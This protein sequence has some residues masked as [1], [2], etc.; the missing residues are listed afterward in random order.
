MNNKS[1]RIFLINSLVMP[2]GACSIQALKP[3]PTIPSLRPTTLISYIPKVGSTWQYVKLNQYNSETVEIIDE[4]I[5][6]IENNRYEISRES[7]KS[8]YLNNEVHQ[9]WGMIKADSDWDYYQTYQQ[10]IP[11][12]VDLNQTNISR[13]IQTVYKLGDSSY[14]LALSVGI[15]QFGWELVTTRAGVFNTIRIEKIIRFQHN[16]S[17]RVDSVR[18]DRYWYSPEVGRWVIREMDGRYF[19]LSGRQRI[20]VR[21]DF[22][23]FEL[24]S[25][26]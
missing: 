20:D 4:K 12:Y 16:D 24:V 23:R 9:P 21:E 13:Y 17:T 25:W 8:N 5:I 3:V 18:I 1:R 6:S 19:Y 2:L 11:V 14:P 26:T 22:W 15:R 7:Q 10:E